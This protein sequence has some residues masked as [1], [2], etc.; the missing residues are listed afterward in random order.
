MITFF[1]PVGHIHP[2]V[3]DL[4]P[5]RTR[6]REGKLNALFVTNEQEQM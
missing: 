5:D 6:Q 2:A 1:S 4:G 3:E